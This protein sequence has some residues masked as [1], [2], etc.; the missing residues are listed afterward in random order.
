MASLEAMLDAEGKDG[1]LSALLNHGF[2]ADVP[3]AGATMLAIADRDI[4]IARRAAEDFGRRFYAVRAEAT[5]PFTRLEEAIEAAGTKGDKPLLLADTA[6]QIGSGA[7]GDTTHVLRALIDAGIRNA[8]VVPIWDP[9]AVG[10]CQRVGI[11]AKLRLRIGGKF[12]PH[13]GPP[14]DADV[15]VLFLEENASQQA[16]RGERIAIGNIAVVRVEGIEVLL[17]DRRVNVFTPS[18][19][20]NHGIT[21]ADKQVI[22]IK[23]LYKHR[24]IFR[25]ITRD[26]LFVATPG[27]SNPDWKSLP[28]KRLLRPMWPLDPDPL[29]LDP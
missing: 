4:E 22:A 18:I 11:G 24:D 3:L 6:D 16:L 1:V 14:L 9:L 13:S 25:S 2:W 23:N 27:T 19:F 12:E 26:Q 15:E 5:L 10:I 8:A 20:E 21:I 17:S 29:G 28:F 7:P